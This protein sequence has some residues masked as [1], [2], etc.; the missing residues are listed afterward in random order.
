MKETNQSNSVND[1]LKVCCQKYW[2]TSNEHPFNPQ[3]LANKQGVTTK[4]LEWIFLL[5]KTSTQSWDDITKQFI[6]SVSFN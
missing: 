1:I 3:T 6:K 5:S 4:Q 2:N